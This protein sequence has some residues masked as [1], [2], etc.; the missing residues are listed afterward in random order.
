MFFICAPGVENDTKV[1][2]D[3]ALCE[4]EIIRGKPI[5]RALGQLVKHVNNTVIGFESFL[6]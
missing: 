1:A 3:V 6:D 2:F 5:V 4:P